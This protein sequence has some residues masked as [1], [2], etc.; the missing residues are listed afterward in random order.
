MKLL[1]IPIFID[2]SHI[3]NAARSLLFFSSLLYV[4]I[5]R[6]PTLQPLNMKEMRKSRR[7]KQRYRKKLQCTF[8][9]EAIFVSAT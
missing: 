3:F 9:S 2:F 7:P 1:E 4:K 5:A 6:P 8:S